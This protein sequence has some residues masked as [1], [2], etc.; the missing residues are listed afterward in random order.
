MELPPQQDR[1]L[2]KRPHS[3]M[4]HKVPHQ[5]KLHSTVNGMRH[6]SELLCMLW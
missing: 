2:T 4:G 6:T 5:G 3:S 1:L